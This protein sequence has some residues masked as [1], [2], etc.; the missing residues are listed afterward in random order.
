[1]NMIHEERSELTN[2]HLFF[3]LW[4]IKAMDSPGVMKISLDILLLHAH[5]V[6]SM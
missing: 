5:S 2:Y 3:T 4:P 6:L 1:M